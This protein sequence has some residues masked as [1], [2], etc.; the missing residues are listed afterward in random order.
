MGRRFLD[1]CSLLELANLSD[2]NTADICLSSVTLQ[3]LENIKTSA[4]KDSE[5]KY[6]ARVAV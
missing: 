1:T 5:T 4:N 2:I 6:R 3:E